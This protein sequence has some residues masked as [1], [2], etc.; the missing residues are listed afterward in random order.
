MHTFSEQNPVSSHSWC[1]GTGLWSSLKILVTEEVGSRSDR[2]NSA[3][4]LTS[5]SGRQDENEEIE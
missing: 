5:T 1:T 4:K 2:N 3:T